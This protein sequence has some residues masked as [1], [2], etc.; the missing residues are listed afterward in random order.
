MYC[1]GKRVVSVLFLFLIPVLQIAAPPTRGTSAA[2]PPQNAATTPAE[3]LF[4]DD[5]EK[6]GSTIDL[7]KW[8]VS[9]TKDTDVIEV[10]RNG[11]PNI[12]GYAVITDSGDHGGTHHGHAGA[13]ASQMSFSRGRNLRCTF[14][15]AMP[16]HTGTGFSGPWHST[17]VMTHEKYSMLNYMTGSIGF[18]CNGTYQN[19]YME[20]DENNHDFDK[21]L[22]SGRLPQWAAACRRFPSS[23][24]LLQPRFR[25][26]LGLDHDPCLAG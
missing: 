15:V 11:W 9:K 24:A 16:A 22:P 19:P 17:N 8:R 21:S 12:G 7:T 23:L 3:I 26:R 25:P 20:W 18:Y 5:F 14:K 13:I 10:R 6:P 2:E 1:F 4:S